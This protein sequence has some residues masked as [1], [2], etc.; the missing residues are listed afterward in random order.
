MNFVIIGAGFTGAVL[1]QELAM[2]GYQVDVFEERGHV[3]G[4]CYSERDAETGVLLHKYGPHIFHTDSQ[5]VWE[6]VNKF[7]K[8]V[9]YINR[10][11]TTTQ[12]KVF[13]LPINLHTIN[14]YFNKTFTPSEAM[15][16]IYSV[17]EKT[18]DEPESFEEQALKFVGKD[19]YEA[20]LE[21]YTIKQWGISPKL[22]PAAVLK[23]LPVRF[24]YND[25]YF[26]HKYQGV[27]LKG[28]TPIVEK[29]LEHK[30]ISVHLNAVCTDSIVNDFDHVF[31]TG[32]ID[33]W[34]RY[35]YGKLTYRTL[36][37][38]RED[39]NG[40]YQG[41]AV[42]NYGD[43]KVPYTRISEHKHFAPWENHTKTVIYKEYSLSCGKGD[44]PYYPVRLAR[45]KAI[46]KEY[47][48]LAKG[49]RGASFLGRLGTY[50]YLD[51]DVT[52]EEALVASERVLN[53]INVGA[54]IP[55]FFN[56]SF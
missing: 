36:R 18:I 33:S 5:K 38:K 40:D 34:F 31:V 8:L 2:A 35:L 50:R 49:Q 9:P 1:A 29:L 17:A 44:I 14:Q 54:K 15:D 46:L 30:N 53:A 23:R 55:V 24:D 20:F 26:S 48:E 6:Y 47:I 22:L 10:V 7:G 19:L 11:K 41:C 43:I 12:G 27:P 39:Y 52:I 13:S 16:F 32:P 42:M 28:Y 56:S 45:D 4:N 25:N 51:M 3:A 37:F 21:G